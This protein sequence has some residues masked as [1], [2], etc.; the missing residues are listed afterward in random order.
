MNDF[1]K[2]RG[3]TRSPHLIIIDPASD[4]P[5]TAN[6]NQLA[7]SSPVPTTYH[8]PALFGMDSIVAEEPGA[9]CGMILL[10]SAS[11]VNDRSPWQRQLEAW[12]ERQFTARLP[13]LAICFG[14]QLVASMFGATV[15]PAVPS[16]AYLRGLRQVSLDQA[17]WGPAASGELVGQSLWV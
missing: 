17:A 8:L 2:F 1:D 12:L 9:A 10:G 15:G 6:A 16:G 7:L 3:V 13:T 14:H 4:R 11:S 5:E